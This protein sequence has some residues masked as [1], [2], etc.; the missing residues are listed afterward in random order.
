MLFYFSH[1]TYLTSTTTCLG[2]ALLDYISYKSDA[3]RLYQTTHPSPKRVFQ[4]SQFA[5]PSTSL[6]E[7]QNTMS[8][9]ETMSSRIPLTL[10]VATTSNLGIGLK[11]ALPWRLRSEMQYFARVTTRVAPNSPNGSKNAVIMGRKTW[12]SIPTKFRPLKNRL[13]V[14][15]SRNTTIEATTGSGTNAWEQEPIWVDSVERAVSILSEQQ[16]GN[17][18]TSLPT[19]ARAFIIGGAQIYEATRELNEVDSVLVTRVFGEWDVDT[20][21]PVD[22]DKEV[23][24]KR[25]SLD[26]LR[27]FTGEN[28]PEGRIKEGE[29]EFE[30]R[31]YKK[32]S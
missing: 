14:V 19:I 2:L 26:E 15:I 6:T 25:A 20:Y 21:F 4:F 18:A 10:I 3:L 12:E 22:Y 31:L 27:D 1:L 24:W 11:G 23:K 7:Y 32:E 17:S 29:T 30:Y 13:N 16:D 28:I 9:N 8:T 5:E